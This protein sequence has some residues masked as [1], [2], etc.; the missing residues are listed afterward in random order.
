MGD[1]TED[2]IHYEGY[3][4]LLVMYDLNKASEKGALKAE[5]FYQ[6]YK[7]TTTKFYA[8][9]ASGQADIENFRQN[10]GITYP[11]CTTDPIT[12]KTMLR[13]NPGLMLIRNGV[14]Q[15]KWSWRNF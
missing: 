14:I 1:I 15:G 2:I 4:Y 11:F 6:Q 13:S 8:L 10:T 9:T 5:E 3:T 7:N 12:L